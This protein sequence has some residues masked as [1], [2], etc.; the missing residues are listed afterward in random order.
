MVPA[1][2][3]A[4][5]SGTFKAQKQIGARKFGTTVIDAKETDIVEDNPCQ[6]LGSINFNSAHC[7]WSEGPS[8]VEVL[9]CF[10]LVR[11]ETRACND[12]SLALV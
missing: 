7:A 9:A 8:L 4:T 3:P 10:V 1:G 2:E 12:L 5:K 6:V 11:L